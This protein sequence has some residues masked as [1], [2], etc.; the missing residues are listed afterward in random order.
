MCS[1]RWEWFLALA[2]LLL[3]HLFL[4]TSIQGPTIYAIPGGNV[5]L[6]ISNLPKN[7]KSLIWFYTADQK[8]VEWESGD[9][10]YFDTKFKDRA[11]LDLNSGTL[12]IRK[13]Q[14]EDSSTYLLRVQKDTEDEDEW[15]IPLVVLDPVPKPV[16]KVNKTE[17]VNSCHLLLSCVIQDQPVNYTWYWESESFPKQLQNSVLEE[18]HT[19]QNYSKSYTCQVSNPVSSQNSTI[20]FTSSCVLAFSSGVA[21]MATWP[22][23]MVTTLLYL[24]WT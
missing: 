5:S 9:P 15:K 13:V 2:I 6:Q 14:K 23:I 18:V 21:W 22:V 8:I 7:H 24:L 12:H 10:K 17:K 16:I 19:P 1:R 11:A 20:K 3:P 4:A